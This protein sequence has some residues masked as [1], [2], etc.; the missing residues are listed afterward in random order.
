MHANYAKLLEG[1][2]RRAT[3]MVPEMKYEDYANRLKKR[4]LPSITFISSKESGHDRGIYC[5]AEE[6]EMFHYSKDRT[7]SLCELS[8]HGISFLFVNAVSV[9]GFKS[10]VDMCWAYGWAHTILYV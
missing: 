7:S 10:R 3:K 9:N 2:Q 1:V 5:M 4:A 6:K 8:M